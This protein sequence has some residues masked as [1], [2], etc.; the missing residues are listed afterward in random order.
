[1]E[2]QQSYGYQSLCHTCVRTAKSQTKIRKMSLSSRALIFTVALT[3]YVVDAGSG[4]TLCGGE[5]VDALQFVCEDRGFYFSRPTSRANSRRSQKGIVEECCFQSCD[6]NLLE[7]YCAKPA[8]SERDVSANSLQVIPALPVLPPLSKDGR[9]HVSV[10]YSRHE[11]W[12]R[13]AAPTEN[14]AVHK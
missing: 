12:Q 1:M 11:A 9:R 8:K 7:Q 6:L 5:L 10:K 14:R 2:Q 4:E 13:K 3:M